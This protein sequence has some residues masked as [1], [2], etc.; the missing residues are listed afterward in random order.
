MNLQDLFKLE[1]SAFQMPGWMRMRF[2]KT[3]SSAIPISRSKYKRHQGEKEC[4]RRLARLLR[5]EGFQ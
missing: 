3:R 4:S 2:R 5:K 1:A